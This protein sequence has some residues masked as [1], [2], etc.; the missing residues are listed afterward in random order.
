MRQFITVLLLISAW[1]AVS[2]N[3]K[4]PTDFLGYE[5]GSKFTPHHRVVDYCEHVARNAGNQVKLQYYGK[6]YEDRPLL[7]L[8]ISSEENIG[9]LEKI[10]QAH[11]ESTKGGTGSEKAIVWLSYNVHGNESSSTEASMQTIYELLTTR[12]DYLENSVV[13]LDPCINPDGRDRYVNWYRQVK[14]TPLEVNPLSREH[15][16]GWHSGRSNHYMFDLNRDWAW[17]T[18]VESRQRIV[19]YNRWL[20]HVHVDFHEQGVDYPYYFAPAAEPF[21][22]VITDFQ[23]EFQ[24]IIGKNHAKYFDAKGWLY[25]TRERF[26]LFY[27]SYG[28]TY[29]TYNGAIGMTY[30]Q[31]GGGRAGLGVLTSTSDTLTLKDRISHHLTTGL[32][33]L[34]VASEHSKRLN[35]EFA[36]FFKSHR[37]RYKSYLLKGRKDQLKNLASWLDMHHIKYGRGTGTMVKGYRYNTQKNESFKSDEQT[38]VIGTDQPKGTLVKVLFEPN[39]KLSDSLTYDITAWSLPY[40]HGLD[41]LASETKVAHVEY[42]AEETEVRDLTDEAYAFF[43]AWNSMEDARFLTELLQKGIRV[44]HARE[45]FTIDDKTY[46]RGSLIITKK[47]NETEPNFI[48]ILTEVSNNHQKIIYPTKTGWIDKGRDLGSRHIKMLEQPRVAMLGDTPT[49]TINFGEIW[50]FF[51]Q[52]LKYPLTILQSDRIKSAPLSDFDIL[53]LPHG[54]GYK[55]FL[56]E[57]I[58]E[59]LKKWVEDGGQ[60]VLVGGA[61]KGL[62]DREGF[63]IKERELK[64]DSSIVDLNPHQQT[65]RDLLKETVKGAIFKTWVDPTHPLAFGYNNQYYTLKRRNGSYDLLKSGNV[66]AIREHTI[67]VAGFSG[68]ETAER[69]I[70]S[71]VF[72]VQD[73]GKGRVV[74]FVDNPLFRGFWENGKLFFANML[75]M[76]D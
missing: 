47:D 1:T 61:I 28:D 9:S 43:T 39:A 75:F 11:L 67:P 41:A 27:P 36:S 74:Y 30:E 22:E 10:R 51:E 73:K 12:Q 7:L 24:R 48:D 3:L 17:L 18:Q 19:E 69:L 26:D 37:Y 62:A 5:L 42:Q 68:S 32:S 14:N 72:G 13:I 49:S 59:K 44:R 15:H 57:E 55:E 40:A 6:T 64:K 50:Y 23:R 35:Q 63:D 60:L 52:E 70:N 38:L 65:A 53:I 25:F 33:T 54:S 34:E 8:Y 56:S 4:S 31:G 58:L 76:L 2:Q 45:P 20:P 16:E 21:H 71:L 46:Q 66:V 29:P